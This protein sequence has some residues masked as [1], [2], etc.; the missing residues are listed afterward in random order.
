MY[1]RVATEFSL[2]S[3]R[4]HDEQR[5]INAHTFMVIVTGN[6]LA[7][8]VL[9]LYDVGNIFLKGILPG[10]QHITAFHLSDKIFCRLH[11]SFS[12]EIVFLLFF[13]NG[14]LIAVVNS[15]RRHRTTET[16]LPCVLF[17]IVNL[18]DEAAG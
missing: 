17:V 15:N 4:L 14:L 18:L 6:H 10:H 7:D 9:E 11:N 8:H 3:G 13:L 2:A 12:F 16:D 5:F 1:C